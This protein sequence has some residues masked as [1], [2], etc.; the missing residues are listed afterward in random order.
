MNTVGTLV[1]AYYDLIE[2]VGDVFKLTVPLG[3]NGDYILIY[4]EGGVDQNTK[5]SKNEIVIIRV[6]IVT[7]G[8]NEAS[9]VACEAL[10]TS[11]Y[12]LVMPVASGNGLSASGLS[13]N[14][15]TRENY[16]YFIEATAE[17]I[18]YKKTSR[19][20]QRVHQN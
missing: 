3:H 6:D 13:I 15:V 12:D 14:N 5:T 11:I 2:G 10:D 9:Q 20:S 16:Q 18:I 7:K 19:Y 1:T 17:G 4:P 8:Q